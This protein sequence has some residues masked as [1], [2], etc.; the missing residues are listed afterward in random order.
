MSSNFLEYTVEE[1]IEK[2][3]LYKP[4]DGNHGNI[5]PKSKDFV[6][7]GVPFIMANDI[8]D[9][10]ID[11]FNC[12]Y[13]TKDLSNT[14]KKGFSKP[15]DVLLTHKGTI[16]RTTIVDNDYECVVLT[17]QV[18]YYRV[19][20]GIDNKYLKYYF[21]SQ[22]FQSTLYNRASAGSTRAYLG[23]TQ[24]RKL[25]IML[26][27]LETQ[28][29]IANILSALDDKIE[30]NKRTAEKLE[31]VAQ[32]LFKQWFVDFNFPNE[33][34]KSYKDNGGKMVQSELGEI[35]KGWE[36]GKLS[37]FGNIVCGKTPSKN[38]AE[39]YGDEVDFIKIPDMHN[40]IFVLNTV[41]NLSSVGSESQK[42]KLLPPLSILTSCI[43]TVGVVSLNINKAHT[44]QQINSIIPFKDEYRYYLYFSLKNNKNTLINM[45]S[46]GSTT[47]NVNT[48]SFSNLKITTPNKEILKKYSVK[49]NKIF[50]KVINIYYENEKL[51]SLRDTL[52]PK[53]MSGEI[54]V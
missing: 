39:Y 22:F 31:E 9:G 14:L 17:P 33:D 54:E 46:A 27:P 15:G 52:L 21:D 30:N 28:E 20:S 5:H 8:K 11:Y 3:M 23:I 42:N 48:T 50:G 36:V 51:I 18:T 35:P 26:P 53:L 44:N 34:G 43:A 1:L 19:K 49:A 16:G 2:N 6:N 45:G 38:K 32:T 13:I 4:L 7:T 40:N 47:L 12:K 29:K 10:K 41:D 37:H 24:Q 25:P